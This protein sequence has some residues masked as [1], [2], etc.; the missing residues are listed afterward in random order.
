MK[1]IKTRLRNH[2]SDENLT[3]LMR[4]AIEGPDLSE[5]NFNEILDIFKETVIGILF[6]YKSLCKEMSLGGGRGGRGERSQGSPP[7]PP[8]YET[9]LV[10]NDTLLLYVYQFQS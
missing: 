3:H 5:V 9:L 6:Y 10:L 7:P 4:I 8:L 2:L 1:M